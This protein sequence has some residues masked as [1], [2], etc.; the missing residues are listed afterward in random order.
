M[1][2]FALLDHGL[3][4]WHWDRSRQSLSRLM[5]KTTKWPL[6]PTKTRINLGIHP[7][8]SD[9]WLSAWRNTGSSAT[10][11]H[12]ANTLIRL[13]GCPDWSESLLGAHIILLVLSW[14][15][16]NTSNDQLL[17]QL[18]IESIGHKC[19]CCI[20]HKW[21]PYDIL[22]EPNNESDFK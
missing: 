20:I 12:T 15:G 9:S 6:Y 17:M 21:Y 22:L 10:I 4:T 7:V 1:L 5:K 13:G 16:S 2:V 18:Q 8:S 14:G 19:K 11:E 3:P